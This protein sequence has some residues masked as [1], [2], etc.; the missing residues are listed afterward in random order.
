VYTDQSETWSHDHVFDQDQQRAGERRTLLIVIITAIMMVVEIAAGLIYGS[1][2][3]LA[4][5][6]HMGSHAAALGIAVFAYV[7]SRRMAADRRFSFGVGKINSLAGFASAVMLL[8]L[9][10]VMVIEST[11]RLI[12][13]LTIAFDQALIVAVVGL[14]V[15]GVSA[16][17]LVST[18]HEH[19][20][21]HG[22]DHHHDHN[23][24]AAYLHVLADALTSLLAIAA[25]LAGKYMGA[26]W[27]DP[28]MGIVGAILVARWSYGLIRDTSKVLL[29]R[30]VED[31]HVAGLRE[32]IE[33]QSNDRVA[34]LHVWSIGHG[35]YAA[36]IAVVSDDPKSP[37]QYK[38][39]IP[40]NLKIV[41]VTVEVHRSADY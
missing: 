11:D 22:H 36:E 14:I 19:G 31:D 27:L 6:L 4:D 32:S 16:W 5:G 30:Q 26:M 25:L 28:V 8:G 9:A 17:V 38:S 40:T 24:R 15:N 1:M 12:N 37:D 41:H 39:L 18:P 34:D 20:H 13:P 3:L 2:A 29:D 10:L 21:S 33:A 23:L 35:I 7:I